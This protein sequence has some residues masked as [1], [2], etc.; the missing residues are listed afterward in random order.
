MSVADFLKEGV[1][2]A[3]DM[4]FG[5][6]GWVVIAPLAALVPKRYD[7]IAVIGR[8]DGKFLDNSKY[9]FIQASLQS[10]YDLRVVHVTERADV[11]AL[12]LDAGLK[13]LRFP[14]IRAIWFL[15]RCGSV[16]VDSIEWCEKWRYALL[17]RAKI[18]QLWHGVGFKRIELD[19]WRNEARARRGASSP[20]L[21]WARM[22]RKRLRGRVP[23]Y[24][25]V[26][27]TS[28][29]YRDKVF[30]PAFRSRHVLTAGYPRNS[31]GQVGERGSQLAWQ[32]VD[33]QATSRLHAW[34]ARGRTLVLV[35]P[36]FRDTRAT[37]MGLDAAT[38]E[39]IE[40]FCKER[41]CEMLFKFHPYEHGAT[42]IAGEHLHVL[43][44]NSDLYPLLPY[45]DVLVTDYSSI[46]MDFLLLDR[47]ILFYTPDLKAY[48]ERDRDIQFDFEEMTPGPKLSNWGNVLDSLVDPCLG[49]R[50]KERR[51][52]LRRLAFDGVSQ[53]KA[54]ESILS[55][56]ASQQWIQEAP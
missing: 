44:A 2:A 55:F 36:T 19:K 56:M 25:V 15:A 28:T 48:I 1:A 22:L 13:S 21:L 33:P 46:Y 42:T 38:Q 23:L 45:I 49:D 4:L 35:A 51:T 32:N 29:F 54:T 7:W 43:G 17:A 53:H 40:A 50:W 24:D 11:H 10:D 52:E 41:A 3:L 27:T 34:K 9:F 20:F 12:I 8:S 39:R 5:A 16:V 37:P 18:V 47:P 6:L 31:F 14:S 30:I 26:V